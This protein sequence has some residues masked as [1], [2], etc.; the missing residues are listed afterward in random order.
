MTNKEIVE[1]VLLMA[2]MASPVEKQVNGITY[3]QDRWGYVLGGQGEL[4]TE[5][6]A[7]RWASMRRSGRTSIYFLNS[8]KK[9]YTPPRRIVDCSG[10]V[11]QA[12]RSEDPNYADRTA[13]GFKSQFEKKGYIRDIPETAGLAV[14]K[15]GHIGIYLGNGKVCESR[16]VAHGV[17]I[18]DIS[19][20]KWTHYG[21][22]RCVVYDD[23]YVVYEKEVK[24]ESY[25]IYTVKK[26]DSLWAISRK[27][28]T[29]VREL[30]KLNNL[31]KPSLIFANQKIKIRQEGK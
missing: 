13:N 21:K 15:S 3:H 6:L 17:V 8:A 4:Y 9:W 29:T 27:Y 7:K 1:Q 5:K 31:K 26:G 2:G 16:G 30:A 11:V 12:F 25:I 18:S 14:W 22:L 19:T 24:P 28:K 10:M 23:S 20:Q